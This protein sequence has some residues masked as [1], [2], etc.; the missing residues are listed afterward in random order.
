MGY[1]V[2]VL[3]SSAEDR[4]EEGIEFLGARTRPDQEAL[5]RSGRVRRP[6]AIFLEGGFDASTRFRSLYPAAPIV[7]VGQ[8]IDVG[9]DRA[10]FARAAEIDLYAM[11]SPGQ[12]ADYCVRHARLRH[13]FV[14]IRN[15]AA[16]DWV[17]GGLS[18]RP[19]EDKVVWVGSWSKKGLRIWVR[20]M[21]RV[22]ADHPTLTWTLCGPSYGSGAGLPRHLFY[23]L[24][25][26]RD[27]VSVRSLP[28]R[29]LAEEIMSARFVLSSFGNECGPI[30]PVDALALGRPVVSGNDMVYKY[31]NPDGAGVRVSTVAEGET[32]VR[33]LLANPDLC[34]RLGD[35]GRDLVAREFAEPNQRQDLADVLSFLAVRADL[36]PCAAFVPTTYRE[37]RRADWVDK[38]ARKWRTLLSR[39]RS[40]DPVS[41]HGSGT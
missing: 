22:L 32:A 37:Q 33:H 36:G 41:D 39:G 17:Y 40:A 1:R 7:H 4:V 28:L 15:C 38:V 23:G 10:A 19:A 3:G 14:L 30:S 8:N 31:V 13:K 21:A 9:G 12:F 16:V 5:L 20:V 18:P 34:A 25:L 24:D 26:P 35:R 6:G 11:V 2:Q 27:R 29:R